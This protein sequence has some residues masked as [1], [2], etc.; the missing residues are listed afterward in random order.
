MTLERAS[1]VKALGQVE[2]VFALAISMF[3]YRERTNALELCGMA[4]IAV[5]V[6]V[7]VVS[8]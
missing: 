7:L 2:F 1:Y 6:L 5:G 8:G 4:L 3:F